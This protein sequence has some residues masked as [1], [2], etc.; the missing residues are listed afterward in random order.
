[1]SDGGFYLFGGNRL[2]S[3]NIWSET[4]YS[5]SNTLEIFLNKLSNLGK[6]SFLK[7]YSDVDEE[8]DL[9]TIIEEMPKEMTA[10]QKKLK[11]WILK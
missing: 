9:K 4:P 7:K 2:I 6:V 10:S 3:E 5:Q 1:M 11:E 8:K